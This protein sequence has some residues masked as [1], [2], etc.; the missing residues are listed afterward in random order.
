MTALTSS[1]QSCSTSGDATKSE[2]ATADPVE[3]PTE[4]L[5][6]PLVTRTPP[7]APETGVGFS[8]LGV[9]AVTWKLTDG[10]ASRTPASFGKWDGF[11]T[12]RPMRRQ[13]MGTV[14]AVPRKGSCM[15]ARN[16]R[17]ASTGRSCLCIHRPR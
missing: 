9:N 17:T 13:F 5:G 8:W 11:N 15:G 10:E 4:G 2:I 14:E 7:L 3:Y 12:E 6:S 1:D 16:R